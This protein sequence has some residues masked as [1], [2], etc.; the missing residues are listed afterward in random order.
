MIVTVIGDV[1]SEAPVPKREVITAVP[2]FKGRP[3]LFLPDPRT[4]GVGDRLSMM[5][6]TSLLL[7]LRMA[8]V[9]MSGSA[10]DQQGIHFSRYLNKVTPQIFIFYYC[11]SGTHCLRS[12]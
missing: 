6:I 1:K 3:L 5:S 10:P 7:V 12:H 4:V 9:V 11:G 8:A 2:N